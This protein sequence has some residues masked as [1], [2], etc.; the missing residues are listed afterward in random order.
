MMK[1]FNK[2]VDEFLDNLISKNGKGGGQKQVNK[3]EVKDDDL[4]A[5]IADLKK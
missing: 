2:Q 5:M 3:D 4:T 1:W